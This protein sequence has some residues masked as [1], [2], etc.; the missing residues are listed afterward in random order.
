MQ[1]IRHSLL[2]QR[3]GIRASV[4][5]VASVDKHGDVEVRYH[6]RHTRS[7]CICNAVVCQTLSS[8]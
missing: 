3:C 2:L 1:R 8:G 4:V 7:Y 5:T 6:Q